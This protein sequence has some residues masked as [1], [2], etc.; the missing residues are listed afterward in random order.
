MLFQFSFKSME[1]V[2]MGF[3]SKLSARRSESLFCTLMLKL[4]NVESSIVSCVIPRNFSPLTIL[5]PEALWAL[6][7]DYLCV[8]IDRSK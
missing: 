2:S 6:L 1:L 5:V 8:M 4:W 7:I 3:H